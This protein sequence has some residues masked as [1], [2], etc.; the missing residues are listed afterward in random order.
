MLEEYINVLRKK[1]KIIM[2]ALIAVSVLFV[3]MAIFAFSEFEISNETETKYD[4]EFEAETG[5]GDNGNINQVNDMS[6]NKEVGLL[7]ICFCIVLCVLIICTTIGVIYGKSK[8]EDQK[9]RYKNAFYQE[10]EHI[11]KEEVSN[12]TSDENRT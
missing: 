12:G 8:N 4:I 5:D 10:E 7:I 3:G 2:I 9:N 1:N 6:Q 11:K